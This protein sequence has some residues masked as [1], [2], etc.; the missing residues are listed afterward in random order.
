MSRWQDVLLILALFSLRDRRHNKPVLT[1]NR[2]QTSQFYTP[3]DSSPKFY[4]LIDPLAKTDTT[5][6]ELATIIWKT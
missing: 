4:T 1:I 5:E 2:R 3:L 6:I